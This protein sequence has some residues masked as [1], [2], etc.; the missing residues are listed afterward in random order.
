VNTVSYEDLSAA[1]QAEVTGTRHY[2][3]YGRA[4]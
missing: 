3:V 1:R 2:S 4:G